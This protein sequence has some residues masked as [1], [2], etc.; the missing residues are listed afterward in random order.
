MLKHLMLWMAAFSLFLIKSLNASSIV[1][2]QELPEGVRSH[3]SN[4]LSRPTKPHSLSA[5]YTVPVL[6]LF[7]EGLA[8]RFP[9]AR[10]VGD[11]EERDLVALRASSEQ[12]LNDISI[13]LEE[14]GILVKFDASDFLLVSLQFDAIENRGHQEFSL[15]STCVLTTSP[16]SFCNQALSRL[17]PYQVDKIKESYEKGA[18]IWY[19][20]GKSVSEPFGGVAYPGIGVVSL[21]MGDTVVKKGVNPVLSHPDR[22]MI[23]HEWLHALGAYQHAPSF[24]D[25]YPS[26]LTARYSYMHPFKIITA[27][28]GTECHL[29]QM[30][31]VSNIREGVSLLSK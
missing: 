24:C 6:L 31:S 17:L 21:I 9:R 4:K 28:L 26:L 23:T 30:Q 20:R 16:G 3:L 22:Q 13:L 10:V 5:T 27:P 2:Y 15:L 19:L 29:W 8:S 18:L 11:D 1:S 7:D 12:A 14:Y 25:N